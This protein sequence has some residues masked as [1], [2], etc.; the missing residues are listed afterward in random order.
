MLRSSKWISEES[1]ISLRIVLELKCV[2]CDITVA[3][4]AT[5]KF[6]SCILISLNMVSLIVYIDAK[7]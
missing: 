3:S 7:G 4:I 2:Q 6:K 1:N 5:I